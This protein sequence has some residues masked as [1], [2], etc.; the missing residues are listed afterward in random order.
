MSAPTRDPVHV[1]WVTTGLGC[2]G[3][4]IAVTPACN[5]S[6]ED[7]IPG[8]FP[9]SPPLIIY[10]PVLAYETGEDFMRPWFDAAAGKLDPFIL[11]LEGSVPNEETSGDGY[12]ATLGVDPSSG[13]P[14]SSCTW[15]D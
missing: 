12:W 2:D 4:S 10:T 11:V 5:P 13:E 15:I 1:L 6:F 9:G 3:D 8:C 14:I 7:L